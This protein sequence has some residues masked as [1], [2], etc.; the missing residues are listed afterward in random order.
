MMTYEELIKYEQ[1]RMNE[2]R[3][4]FAVLNSDCDAFCDFVRYEDIT[5]ARYTA[6]QEVDF[7]SLGMSDEEQ[8][9]L[10]ESI[11]PAIVKICDEYR[12]V[13]NKTICDIRENEGFVK[14]SV[15]NE[16]SDKYVAM[17]RKEVIRILVSKYSEK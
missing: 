12:K 4:F 6:I 11:S 14:P 10:A 1:E 13:T 17:L 15:K 16:Y 2:T 7:S 9:I 5:N 8:R 3:A